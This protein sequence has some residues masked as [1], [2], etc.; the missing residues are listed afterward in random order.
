MCVEKFEYKVERIRLGT[1]DDPLASVQQTLDRL[2]A[3]GWELD[4]TEATG[5][6]VPSMWLFMRKPANTKFRGS[7]G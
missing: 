6:P 1:A 7:D 4:H 3:E 2:V 5:S